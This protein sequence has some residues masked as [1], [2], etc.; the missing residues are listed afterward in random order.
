MWSNIRNFIQ[1]TDSKPLSE[2]TPEERAIPKTSAQWVRHMLMATF[3]MLCWVFLFGSM[4][5]LGLDAIR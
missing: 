5:R 4:F 2:Q 3:L 1:T